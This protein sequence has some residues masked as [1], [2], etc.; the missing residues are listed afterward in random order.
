M[1][2]YLALDKSISFG[3]KMV[4][5]EAKKEWQLDLKKQAT[6]D[7]KCLQFEEVMNYK[8]FPKAEIL[9]RLDAFRKMVLTKERIVA[10]LKEKEEEWKEAEEEESESDY[11][12]E[13]RRKAKKQRRRRR[14]RMRME[15]SLTPS[16][17]ENDDDDDSCR[18][19]HSRKSS[20]RS[21]RNASGG[22]SRPHPKPSLLGTPP[23]NFGCGMPMFAHARGRGRGG[24]HEA[25][26]GGSQG[27]QSNEPA[28][29]PPSLMSQ[30]SGAASLLSSGALANLNRP[31]LT[32]EDRDKIA[33]ALIDD[34]AELMARELAKST[35]GRG[36]G[37]ER[38]GRGRGRG[39]GANIGMGGQDHL[40]VIR[41][42]LSVPSP[43]SC[44]TMRLKSTTPMEQ[45]H[46]RGGGRGRMI[47]N[48]AFDDG[49]RLSNK[50]PGIKANLIGPRRNPWHWAAESN[51]RGGSDRG[52][53]RTGPGGSGGRFSRSDSPPPTHHRSAFNRSRSRSRSGSR[54]RH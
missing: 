29:R 22:D 48:K 24:F 4:V 28:P 26:R 12:E 52:S 35:R 8:G 2:L 37:I 14:R 39:M 5:D 34:E 47:S 31:D 45:Q 21:E 36:E 50:L 33:A 43:Q 9:R 16:E 30:N 44:R 20:K 46:Q 42:G 6:L 1:F 40:L 10:E 17:D 13:E 15:R 19:H 23:P 32:C 11:D 51:D 38:R 41:A 25:G 7:I 53:D 27:N 3:T 54:P 18:R 49:P